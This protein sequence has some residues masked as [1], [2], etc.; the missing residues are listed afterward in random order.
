WTVSGLTGGRFEYGA[1]PGVAITSFSQADVVGGLV[2]FVHDGG[3][4]TPGFSLTLDDGSDTAG[5]QAAA[6]SFN[7]VNDAPVVTANALTVSEGGT[8]VLNNAD[9]NAA[10]PDNSTA[11]LTWAVTSLSGGRFEYAAAPGVAIVT[12]SQADIDAGLVRFVHDGGE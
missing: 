8:V 6:V 1:N 9:I 5:P 12:F 2:Y 10:D 7:P 3:E 4:A 11:Q